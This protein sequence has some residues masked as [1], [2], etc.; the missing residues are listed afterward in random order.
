MRNLTY[1]DAVECI[2]LIFEQATKDKGLPLCVGV[3][4]GHGDLIAFGRMDG[5]PIRSVEISRDK[6]YTCIYMGRNTHEFQ[7]MLTEFGFQ[8]NWFSSPRLT[9]LPGGLRIQD[10]SG[11]VGALGVSGRR[12]D[13]DQEL[14]QLAV[15]HIVKK[16]KA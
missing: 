5:A 6:A 9:G 1:A 3:V 14:A 11:C 16:L 12:A 2:D 15:D 4:D 13:Q 7:G 8:V 10:E